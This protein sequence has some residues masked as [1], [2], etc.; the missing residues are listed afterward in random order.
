MA[1]HFGRYQLLR[2]IASGGMGEVL[3]ARIAGQ[4]GFE[5]LL[6]IKRILPNLAEEDEFCTMFF[7]EARI[8]ARLNHPNIV[9]IFDMG[10]VEGAHYLAME[11]VAGDDLRRLQRHA[12]RLGKTIPLGVTCRII[13]DAAAALD[14]AH[15]ARDAS[16]QPLGLVHRDVSPQNV[17]VG[18]DGAVKLIDFGVAK[19][20]GKI[21][22]TAAGVIKGKLSYMSPEQ[23]SGA[24][25]DHRSDVFSLGVLFWESVTG[26]RLFK[27]DNEPLTLHQVRACKVPPPSTVNRALPPE[28]DDIILGVLQREP[29]AR[30]YDAMSLRMAIE[31]FTIAQRLPASS[32]HLV[33]FL[34][35]LYADRIHSERDP[36]WLDQLADDASPSGLRMDPGTPIGAAQ[37]SLPQ[38]A[39][40]ATPRP[41]SVSVSVGTGTG[42]SSRRRVASPTTA[43]SKPVSQPSSR[44]LLVAVGIGVLL[45]AAVG[46]ALVVKN[47]SLPPEGVSV[48]KGPPVAAAAIAAPTPPEVPAAMPG[49]TQVQLV[50]EPPGAEVLVDGVEL[51]PAPVTV[52]FRAGIVRTAVFSLER[53]EPKKISVSAADGPSLVVQLKKK[54]VGKK[55][56][57]PG[58][59][60]R[61]DR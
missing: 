4:Q 55:P 57:G 28:L 30:K 52:A 43:E 3:L 5:K 17:L 60:I 1:L 2:K 16:G 8:A 51:G 21:Q 15:K 18:F 9:Q 24:E 23:A 10:E 25:I 19:A 27:A 20:A 29:E 37:L 12:V 36:A 50:S 33:A 44:G 46:I 26:T 54:V 53:F 59:E 39:P 49:E 31:D 34:E 42:S 13:A 14:H 35:T 58:L 6:V 32:A 47:A 11:Y 41:Q 22:Q 7:D 40:S 56:T 61:T 48:P 38:F 45:V